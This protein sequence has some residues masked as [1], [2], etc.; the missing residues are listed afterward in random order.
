MAGTAEHTCY[1]RHSSD[2][3]LLDLV[4]TPPSEVTHG[5]T[6]MVDAKAY[7][8]ATHA[9]RSASD[10]PL[11]T[12]PNIDSC[13]GAQRLATQSYLHCLSPSA[14]VRFTV[15]WH[16]HA[17]S[18]VSLALSPAYAPLERLF[19][20]AQLRRPRLHM[21]LAPNHLKLPRQL[22]KMSGQV[23]DH[24][25]RRES[26]HRSFPPTPQTFSSMQR[27][28]TIGRLVPRHAS[29][30]KRILPAVRPCGWRPSVLL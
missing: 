20:H 19:E 7:S 5:H 8:D 14:C 21:P 29:Q 11:N 2:M 10:T 4:R 3:S 26:P 15:R 12:S 6:P 30:L 9:F 24:S 25:A 18:L 27:A 28:V 1:F 16:V 17:L 13:A 22:S 23:R